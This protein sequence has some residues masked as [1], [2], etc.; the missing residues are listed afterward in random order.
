[1][2]HIFSH[3]L[4]GTSVTLV[5]YNI[6]HAKGLLRQSLRSSRAQCH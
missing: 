6:Y 5:L 1:M 4:A 2:L 3:F